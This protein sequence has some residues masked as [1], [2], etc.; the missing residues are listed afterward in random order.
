MGIAGTAGFGIHGFPA[1]PECIKSYGLMSGAVG[2][3]L[4]PPKDS[5]GRLNSWPR[6]PWAFSMGSKS[7]GC[8]GWGNPPGEWWELF[9]RL[10]TPTGSRA[11]WSA[12]PRPISAIDYYPT[13][14]GTEK[15]PAAGIEKLGFGEWCIQTMGLRIDKSKADP[16]LVDWD[17]SERRKTPEHGP[18]DLFRVFGKGGIS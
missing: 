11:W 18:K 9:L 12:I 8:T 2:N 4:F 5:P 1:W 13:T 3:P 17:A 14:Q 6:M 15:T 10:P 16:R 7:K